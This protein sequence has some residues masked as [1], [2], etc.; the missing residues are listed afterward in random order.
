MSNSLDALL[1]P[2]PVTLSS[3]CQSVP[4]SYMS[5]Q[6]KEVGLD[7]FFAYGF[8]VKLEGQENPCSFPLIDFYDPKGC[9]V[10]IPMFFLSK[11]CKQKELQSLCFIA[12]S[13]IQM[14]LS[15]GSH[16]KSSYVPKYFT[17]QLVL[18]RRLLLS[19]G[20]LAKEIVFFITCDSKS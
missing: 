3:Y 20:N 2:S 4:Q 6:R 16:I 13:Q 9:T 10:V 7:C 19:S 5:Q 17:L 8:P 12:I 14:F 18:E 15:K 11:L 1:F